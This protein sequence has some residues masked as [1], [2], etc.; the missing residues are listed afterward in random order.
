MSCDLSVLGIVFF[1][2]LLTMLA[3]IIL[4]PTLGTRFAPRYTLSTYTVFLTVAPLFAALGGIGVADM[5]KKAKNLAPF[6]PFFILSGAYVAV[7]FACGNSGGLAEGQAAFGILFLVLVALTLTERA[8]H[9]I[10]GEPHLGFCLSA[11]RGGVLLLCLILSFHSVSK[12][13]LYPYNWWGMNESN[14]WISTE[15]TGHPLTE[16]ITVSPDTA[17]TYRDIV[18]AITDSVAPGEP[19][20]CFPQIPIFYVLT[21]R[22]DPG[23][24]TK[25]QW[26]DVASD[27]AILC[28]IEIIRQHPPRAILIYHT[29][30]YA[31][32]AHETAFRGG[33]TSGTRQMR[34][35]LLAFVGDRGYHHQATYRTE[36]NTLSLWLAP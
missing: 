12:K 25:V 17:A 23:T 30:E 21:D 16:G 14:F 36:S 6:V 13:L 35:F 4:L 28:D 1:S 33:K 9:G 22:P 24:F 18:A 27:E 11:A 2:I 34:D 31:Y 15:Q 8:L 7:S 29:S 26:F 32:D 5:I 19:I 10:K 20:F 3:A